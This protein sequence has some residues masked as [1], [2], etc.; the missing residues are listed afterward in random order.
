MTKVH[1]QQQQQNAGASSVLLSNAKKC[2]G[3]DDTGYCKV[4]GFLYIIILV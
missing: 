3:I 1:Q 4:V 2:E